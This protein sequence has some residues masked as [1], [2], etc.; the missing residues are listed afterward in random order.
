MARKIENR[1]G[2]NFAIFHSNPWRQ[3]IVLLKICCKD[4]NIHENVENKISDFWLH[5]VLNVRA[6]HI[7]AAH[8]YIPLYR[9]LSPPGKKPRVTGSILRSSSLSDVTINCMIS[10]TL[11]EDK[12]NYIDR[13]VNQL[14]VVALSHFIHISIFQVKETGG[15]KR[16][17]GRPKKEVNLPVLWRLENLILWTEKS[18][19]VISLRLHVPEWS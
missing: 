12:W 16:S 3:F 19:L 6:C 18:T 13:A 2:V 11:T 9:Q 7:F 15:T 8:P 1:V 14:K 10:S 4:T 17:R 5:K